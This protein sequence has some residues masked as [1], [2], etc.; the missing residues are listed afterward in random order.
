M[1]TKPEAQ[2]L[3]VDRH[4]WITGNTRTLEKL[5]GSVEVSGVQGK[6]VAW[7]GGAFVG[8]LARAVLGQYDPFRDQLLVV[9]PNLGDFSSEDGLK[10]L[11][12]H[13]VT[14]VAQFRTAPWIA[15]KISSVGRELFAREG[16]AWTKDMPSRVREKLP[17]IVKWLKESLEG[18]GGA[19]SPLLDL[20]PDEQRELIQSVNAVVTLLEGHATHITELAGKRVLD[21]YGAMVERVEERR[22]RPPIVRLLEALGG[23]EMKRQQYLNGR[24]FCRKI[25]EHGGAE[26]L[27]PAWRGPEWAPT[28]DELADP[29]SW[30]ARVAAPSPA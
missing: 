17:E 14:H 22:K 8:M 30:L 18:K 3:V 28:M 26:A 5:F 27:A 21:N 24:E 19:P 9:Y 11:L 12:I 4:A 13:E 25:W 16:M 29:D 10:W 7:E 15:D 20:L 23:I 1:T 6:L 2:L